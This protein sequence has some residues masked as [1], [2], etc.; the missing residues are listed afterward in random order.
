[1]SQ[2]MLLLYDNEANY[3]RWM[4]MSPEEMQQA[5]EKYTAWTEQLAAAGTLRGGEKLYDGTGRVLRG[6]GAAQ[7][8]TDGPFSE[9]K[10]VIGGYFLI[11]AADYD[12]AV[13]IT[14]SCPHL[15]FGGTVEVREVEPMP[16]PEPQP[17]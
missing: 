10:E 3:E 1:M 12:E 16:V 8:V 7:R 4:R 6:T 9:T 2:F 14:S 5:I 13:R 15:A 11:E 17:A